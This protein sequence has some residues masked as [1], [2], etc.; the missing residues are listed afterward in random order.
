[1][2]KLL[3]NPVFYDIFGILV[4]LYIGTIALLNVL[5]DIPLSKTN[6]YLLLGIALAGLIVDGTFVITTFLRKPKTS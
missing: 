2:K 4:F 1:M 5:K 3:R 6:A